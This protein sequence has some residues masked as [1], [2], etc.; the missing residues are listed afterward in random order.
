M[1]WMILLVEECIVV[2]SMAQLDGHS[3]A[4]DE[5]PPADCQEVIV[6]ACSKLP[7]KEMTIRIGQDFAFTIDRSELQSFGNV[8]INGTDVD[9][10]RWYNQHDTL[11]S[12]QARDDIANLKTEDIEI[13]QRPLGSFIMGLIVQIVHRNMTPN[14]IDFIIELVSIVDPARIET[15]VN[16]Q[17]DFYEVTGELGILLD[18][19]CAQLSPEMFCP[20]GMI[21]KQIIYVDK[22]AMPQQIDAPCYSLIV[23]G[24]LQFPVPA[25]FVKKGLQTI[26]IRTLPLNKLL[27][28]VTCSEMVVKYTL[29]P[30]HKWINEI[31]SPAA[32]VVEYQ[33]EDERL[34]IEFHPVSIT[35]LQHRS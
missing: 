9:T 6:S 3:L 15:L 19:H 1:L 34:K 17:L 22:E 20:N 31:P 26:V 5:L 32:F 4:L 23:M 18:N 10:I 25:N 14:D 35:G 12:F 29:D 7:T 27:W 24:Y 2:S 16:A 11:C 13:N 8:T 30:K 28:T 21:V 33:V